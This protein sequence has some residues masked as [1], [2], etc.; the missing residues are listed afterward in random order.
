VDR[1]D[2]AARAALDARDRTGSKQVQ[3]TGGRPA[4]HGQ[5]LLDEYE[6][7]FQYQK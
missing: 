5:E 4:G 7:D 2:A 1:D 6:N 3:M